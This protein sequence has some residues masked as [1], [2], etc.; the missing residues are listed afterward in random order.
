MYF[1]P[2]EEQRELCLTVR[3]FVTEQ[4]LPLEMTLDPDASE[5]SAE[6]RAPLVETA[7]RIGL[8]NLGVPAEDG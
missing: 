3:R 5:L 6:E 2:T 8:Y 1:A 7:K 4:I